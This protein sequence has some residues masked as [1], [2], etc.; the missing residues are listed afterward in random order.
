VFAF[1]LSRVRVGSR[2][3]AAMRLGLASVA[4]AAGIG[5]AFPGVALAAKPSVVFVEEFFPTGPATGELIAYVEPAGETTEYH[6]AYG[7]SSSEWCTAKG[8]KGSPD[9][10]TAPAALGSTSGIH[11]V[12]IAIAGLSAGKGYCG[13]VI[14][15]NGS[16]EAHSEL[17]QFTAGVPLAAGGVLE[18]TGPTTEIYANSSDPAGQATTYHVAYGLASSKW[19]ASI[20]KEGSPEASTPPVSLGFSDTE[21]HSA[22]VELSGLTRGAAYCAEFIS[23]NSSGRAQSFQQ[24]F[25]AGVPTASLFELTATGPG[26]VSFTGEV[27]PVGQ[28][29]TYDIAYGLASSQWCSSA[30]AEGSP[31]LVTSPTAVASTGTSCH[32]VTVV[33]S[34][35]IGG[36]EYCAA[37]ISE[38]GSG[39]SS[40]RERRHFTSG[41]PSAEAEEPFATGL[42]SIGVEV[43]VDPAGQTTQYATEYGLASSMWCR[44]AGFEGS[45]EHVVTP[46]TLGFTDGAF[47]AVVV[48]VTGLVTGEGYCVGLAAENPSSKTV[49]VGGAAVAGIPSATLGAFRSPVVPTGPTAVSIEGEINPAGQ[50]THYQ[51]KYGMTTSQ[52]CN[53]GEGSPEH[54]TPLEPLGFTDG[55]F[56]KVVIALSGL[57]PGDEYCATLAVSN[58]TGASVSTEVRPLSTGFTAGAPAINGPSEVAPRGSAAPIEAEVDPAGQTTHYD[59]EFGLA[60]SMWCRSGGFEGSPEHTTAAAPLASSD[61]SFH[62]VTVEITGLSGATDYCAALTAE[63][64]S[65]KATSFVV[66]FTTGS[67]M[68]PPTNI[69][70]PEVSG[71]AREGQVLI[72]SHGSWTHAPTAYS[73]QWERCDSAGASCHPIVGATA[74]TYTLSAGDVGSTIRVSE[75]TSNEGGSSEPAPSTTTSVVQ[76]AA[77]APVNTGA[78]VVSGS[79]QPGQT[80]SCSTGSWTGSPPPAFTY[81]WLRDGSSVGGATSATYVVQAADQGHTL[82]CEATA[83]NSAG[84]QAATSVGVAIAASPAQI[85]ALLASQLTPAGKAA[86][87]AALLKSGGFSMAFK[88]LDAGT[89]VI[90][91]YQVPHGAKV[92]KKTKPTPIL[93]GAGYLTF[94]AAGTATMQIKLTATGKRLLKHA[95]KLKLTAKGTFTPTGTAAIAATRTFV[96]KR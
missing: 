11:I 14:V 45:P 60:S 93:V 67:G 79:G 17:I 41:A 73:Y 76:P 6:A 35:L 8:A 2:A 77:T 94:S 68:L 25:S 19:C 55:S 29:T 23:E 21:F 20:G 15:Q 46:A 27:D 28:A 49:V 47:H 72:E 62:A 10:A 26:S 80:L 50:T 38:N 90:D 69:S 44:S 66:L 1:A 48:N 63:N 74:Q 31:E 82:S 42:T 70:P 13:E 34:G 54:T 9:H 85:A 30:G 65:S 78:P 33:V 64:A 91:W 3:R 75:T 4:C 32:T 87:I 22:T 88:A 58:P 51:M 95:K 96:L 89:A 39:T 5:V 83:S 37:L 81:V 61:G 24:P 52:W 40:A 43:R 57:T 18:G 59:A 71:T 92:S 12:K 56:H 86:R 84:H 7:L 53:S 16:G 36:K